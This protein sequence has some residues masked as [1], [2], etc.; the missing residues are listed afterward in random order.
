M[1]LLFNGGA[2]ALQLQAQWEVLGLCAPREAGLHLSY[3]QWEIW[4][5]LFNG[6]VEALL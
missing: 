2:G 4:H 6:E 3:P 1:T 5:L